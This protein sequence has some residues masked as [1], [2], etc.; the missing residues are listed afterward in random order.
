MV[1]PIESV[2]PIFAALDGALLSPHTF[3]AVCTA[4]GWGEPRDDGIGLWEVRH[5]ASRTLLVLDTVTKPIT[6]LC[7]LDSHDTYEPEAL[8]EG[9]L[10]KEFDQNFLKSAELLSSKFPHSLASG[11]Y[12]PPYNW[13]FAHF[14]G[15]NSLVALEQSYYDPVMGVQ[16]LLLLQPLTPVPVRS[17]ITAAW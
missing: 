11:T 14:Q 1:Y 5:P 13:R 3:S 4:F 6:L 2:L 12:Q 8:L 17:A 16:L 9:S 10:R 15:L 7:S